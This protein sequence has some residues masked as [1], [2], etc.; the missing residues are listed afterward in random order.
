MCWQH[1]P[2]KPTHAHPLSQGR[3]HDLSQYWRM[4]CIVG[5]SV[6]SVWVKGRFCSSKLQK[7]TSGEQS[8]INEWVQV[9]TATAAQ[10]PLPFKK[11][12]NSIYSL[13]CFSLSTCC[14]DFL[15]KIFNVNM[16]TDLWS[17]GSWIGMGCKLGNC[18][19]IP[20]SG[21]VLSGAG[22]S[23]SLL[24]IWTR[25]FCLI[26]LWKVLQICWDLSGIRGEADPQITIPWGGGC[27]SEVKRTF[28]DFW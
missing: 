18:I 21:D 5:T 14:C 9:H 8:G 19:N 6:G 3:V 16:K 4:L 2:S 26:H 15:K 20:L 11:K 22:T 24:N 13:G 23:P 27:V 25:Q 7:T 17:N 12:I 28:F 1:E 10:P